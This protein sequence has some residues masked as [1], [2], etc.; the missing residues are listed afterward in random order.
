MTA[1]HKTAPEAGITGISVQLRNLSHWFDKGSERLPVLDRIDLDVAAG[2]SVALLGPSGC[3]KSTLLRLM[4][5]LDAPREGKVG[6]DKVRIIG[7]DPSRLLVFQDP[8][9]YPWRTIRQNIALGLEARGLACEHGHR[10]E[11]TLKQVGLEGFGTALP[12]ELSG[13]MAQRAA[14][15]RVLV[16]DPG[17]LL[18]DEPLGRLDA[19]TRLTMQA[20]LLRLW[21]DA[22]FTSILVTHD[23]EEALLLAQRIIIFSARPARILQEIRVDAPYP[24]HRDAPELQNLRRDILETL[25]HS[26]EL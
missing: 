9:L 8:T 10:V 23:V 3:G 4:A 15:A 13:G 11:A 26:H 14:L 20:E 24:R 17:L 25:G 21:Q 22:G 5:G 19:L 18:L 1:T 12:H 16:N 2:E 7:P 6:A